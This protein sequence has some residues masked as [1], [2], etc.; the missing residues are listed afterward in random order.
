MDFDSMIKKIEDKN[1]LSLEHNIYPKLKNLKKLRNRI[2]LQECNGDCDHDYN[3]FNAEDYI[4]MKLILHKIL[5]C[6]EFC[7]QEEVYNFLMN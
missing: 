4:Y 5:I 2:H 3:N 6:P 1:L 7:H